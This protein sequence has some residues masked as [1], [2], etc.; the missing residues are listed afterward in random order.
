M[1]KRCKQYYE[2]ENLLVIK[3]QPIK[4]GKFVDGLTLD[5]YIQDG[6]LGTDLVDMTNNIISTNSIKIKYCPFCGDK[7]ENI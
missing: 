3:N 6:K 7:L 5:L 1:C 4:F 2:N